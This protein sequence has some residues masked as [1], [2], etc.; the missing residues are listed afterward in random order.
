MSGNVNMRVSTNMFIFKL[1]NLVGCL[2][3]RRKQ[4]FQYFSY[5]DSDSD[6][7]SDSRFSVHSCTQ[8]LVAEIPFNNQRQQQ[9]L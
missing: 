2:S 7:D 8:A 5:S 3:L 6:G 9:Q 1:E 4:Y